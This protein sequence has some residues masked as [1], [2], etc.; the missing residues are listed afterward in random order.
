L[1][2]V[3]IAF[4]VASTNAVGRANQRIWTRIVCTAIPGVL[5]GLDTDLDL[6]INQRRLTNPVGAVV[7]SLA[8]RATKSIITNIRLATIAMCVTTIFSISSCYAFV[9]AKSKAQHGNTPQ[10][11]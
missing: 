10:N 7:I 3:V 9:T 8:F 1:I 11:K 6:V 2:A 5:L 4:A